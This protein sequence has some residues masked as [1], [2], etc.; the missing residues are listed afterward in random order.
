[1]LTKKTQTFR[2]DSSLLQYA[3]IP[4]DSKYLHNTTVEIENCSVKSVTAL[5]KIIARFQHALPLVNG[6][7]MFTKIPLKEYPKIQMFDRAGFYYVEQSITI[8]IDL[9]AWEP[10]RLMFQAQDTYQIVPASRPD[11]Q[12]IKEIAKLTFSTDRFHLDPFIQKDYADH[13]FEMWVENSFQ[14]SDNI[15]KFVDNQDTIIGFFIVREHPDYAEFRLAG[16][17]QKYVGKGLG[18]MLYHRMYRLLKEKKYGKIKSVISLNNTQVLNVYM[19]LTHAKFNNPLIV[20][21]KVL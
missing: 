9:T 14:S 18:K 20:L 1:M 12:A 21:H 16:L 17:H 3:I 19:Y 2:V 8:D 10:E 6:D 7:L 5:K 13:R 11:K 15:Y 4:W